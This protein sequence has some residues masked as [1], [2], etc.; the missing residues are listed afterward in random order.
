MSASTGAAR[1]RQR[2]GHGLQRLQVALRTRVRLGQQESW[3]PAEAGPPLETGLCCLLENQ[4]HGRISAVHLRSLGTFGGDFVALPQCGSPRAG[5][6]TK[7]SPCTCPSPLGVLAST[8]LLGHPTQ[9]HPQSH[10][11]RE[12]TDMAPRGTR[13][14]RGISG[15]HPLLALNSPWSATGTSFTQWAR[16]TGVQSG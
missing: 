12:T 11:W 5:R 3:L 1:R 15:S 16:I 7:E 8:G 13:G 14:A 9:V 2:S 6:E 10:P 4:K